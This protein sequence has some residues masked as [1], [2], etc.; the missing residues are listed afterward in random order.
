[1]EEADLTGA[2]LTGA[3]LTGAKNAH[4]AKNLAP[5]WLE[6]GGYEIDQAG[7]II[8]KQQE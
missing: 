2:D 6:A 1:M 5:K 8:K 3:D 7:T 4:L